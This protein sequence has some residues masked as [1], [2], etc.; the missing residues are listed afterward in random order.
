MKYERPNGGEDGKD[1]IG[2]GKM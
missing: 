1:G 2:G